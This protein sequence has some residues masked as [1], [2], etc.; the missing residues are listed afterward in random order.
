MNLLDK[1]LSVLGNCIL[2]RLASA[3]FVQRVADA[4]SRKELLQTSCPDHPFHLPRGQA[5]VGKGH[6][7][8]GGSFVDTYWYS[9]YDGCRDWSIEDGNLVVWI[10]DGRNWDGSRTGLRGV[11]VFTFLKDWKLFPDII[12]AVEE[13]WGRL[14]EREFRREEEEREAER[15]RL[16]MEG[17][18][19]RLLGA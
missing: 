14:L 13:E 10:W 5:F 16:A 19:K 17:I 7:K 2:S 6:G 9:T 8:D 18:E 1:K 15:K 3:L 12:E 4:C 11:W